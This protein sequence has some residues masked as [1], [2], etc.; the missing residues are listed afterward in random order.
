MM[1]K[2]GDRNIQEGERKESEVEQRRRG[3]DGFRSRFRFR[4]RF[5]S[6]LSSVRSA[7]LGYVQLRVRSGLRLGSSAG[8]GLLGSDF[9]FELCFSFSHR[10][11]LRSNGFGLQNNSVG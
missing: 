7:D 4:F 10:F 2:Q 5:G 3:G 1:Q 11:G 6:G 9:R 8:L